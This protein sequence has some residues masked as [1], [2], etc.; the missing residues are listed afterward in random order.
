MAE[1]KSLNHKKPKS[2]HIT[3]RPLK[4]W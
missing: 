2:S 3:A 4:L 1:T